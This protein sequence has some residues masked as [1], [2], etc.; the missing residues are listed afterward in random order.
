MASRQPLAAAGP[1]AFLEPP[2]S[3]TRFV[4]APVPSPDGRRLALIAMDA[5]GQTQLW[6]REIGEPLAHQVE[7]TTGVT[8]VFWSPD[9]QQIGFAAQGQVRRAGVGGGPVSLVVS[10][11]PTSAVWLG[12]GDILLAHTGQGLMRVPVVGGSLRAVSGL[13]SDAMRAPQ[14]VGLDASPDGRLV[15]FSQFGGETGVY[16]ARA[17]GTAKRLLYP[18]QQSPAVFAGADLIVRRDANLLL[19]QRFNPYGMSL[20]GEAFPVAENVSDFDV[21]GGASGSL[22]FIT[23]ARE[24][25]TPTWFS[26]DGKVAGTA[27]PD[28]DYTESR[29]FSRGPL[30][31]IRAQ[32]S[33]R[34]QLG[35]VGTGDVGRRADAAHLG[36]RHR[37]PLHDLSR[38]T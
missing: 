21:A 16:V 25:S 10:A 14:I 1:V 3:G 29:D 33:C 28:G 8:M 12:D 31:G 2:P 32:G 27:G 4:A 22:S 5:T 26:R 11:A 15:L 30:A 6:T 7:G 9:G 18:G 24:I 38:R 37:S 36:S 23:G 34:R 35:R 17:D 20:D 13:A 19:A